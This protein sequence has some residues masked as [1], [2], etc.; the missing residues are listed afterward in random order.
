VRPRSVGAAGRRVAPAGEMADELCLYTLLHAP[1]ESHEALLRDFVTPV[2]AAVRGRPELDS[3]FFARYSEPDWQLRFRVLG[4]PDWVRGTVR[5]LVERALAPLAGAGLF[6]AVD[7]ATYD[8]E[9]ERYGGSEGMALAE[10]VFLHDSLACLDLMAAERA[11]ALEKSRREVSLLLADRLLD[12]LRFGP[13]RRRAFY[14]HGHAWAVETGAWTEVDREQLDRR[15]AEL[16]EGL[17]ELFGGGRRRAPAVR[18]GGAEAARIVRR[19]ERAMRPLAAALLAAH[20]AGRIRQDLV[21]L[22]WS[23]AHMSCNRL[24]IEAVPEAILRYFMHRLLLRGEESAAAAAAAAVPAPEAGAA[25]RESGAARPEAGTAG[26]A[27]ARAGRG[28]PAA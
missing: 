3:L 13:A 21:Y 12:L 26:P 22:A 20:A 19:W 5:P 15:Y 8:R 11:G 18:W 28:G 14:A 9:I 2:A 10:K 4:R 1:R 24:G 16:E 6:T 25:R 27:A 23:Y 7:F 17:L